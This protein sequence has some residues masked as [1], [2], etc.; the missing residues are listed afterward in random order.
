MMN[1]RN[2]PIEKP[3]TEFVASKKSDWHD[4]SWE[5]Y[6]DVMVKL[7]RPVSRKLGLSIREDAVADLRR[8]RR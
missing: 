8:D 4:E 7:F 2:G 6:D 5:R 1:K 3:L